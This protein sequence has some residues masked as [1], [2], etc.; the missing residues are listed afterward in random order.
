MTYVA[1]EYLLNAGDDA[2]GKLPSLDHRTLSFLGNRR[3]WIL[4]GAVVA[5]NVLDRVSGAASMAKEVVNNLF[6]VPKVILVAIAYILTLY[7]DCRRCANRSSLDFFRDFLPRVGWAFLYV[8]P[9]YPFLAVL[10]S[11]CFLL[12]IN[13]FELLKLPLAL[14]NWPIYYGT[15]VR[16]WHRSP[17][18]GNVRW[19]FSNISNYDRTRYF[20]INLLVRPFLICVLEGETEDNQRKD[21]ASV[22][23]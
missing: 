17:V 2:S 5:I 15:L 18:S 6:H 12:V 13:L 21:D 3:N 7:Y 19:C 4:M 16:T 9:V 23:K 22:M 1:T 14:L 10:I 20:L 11:F 8:L